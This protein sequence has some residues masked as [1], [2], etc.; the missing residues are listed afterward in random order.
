MLQKPDAIFSLAVALLLGVPQFS[1]RLPNSLIGQLNFTA[2]G[3]N[4]VSQV[5]KGAWFRVHS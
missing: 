3:R 5:E 2:A 4:P 1:R